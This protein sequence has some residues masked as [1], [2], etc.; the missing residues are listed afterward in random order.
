MET[1]IREPIT[2]EEGIPYDIEIDILTEDDLGVEIPAPIHG[3]KFLFE[4]RENAKKKTAFIS[5]STENGGIVITDAVNGKVS[6]LFTSEVSQIKKTSGIYDFVGFDTAG[7][8]FKIMH[9]PINIKQTISDW[10]V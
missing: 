10:T 7:N 1:A 3:F 9:G 6:I 4:A 2:L 8:P 5:L